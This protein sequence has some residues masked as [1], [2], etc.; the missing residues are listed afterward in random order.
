L[1][2]SAT[3]TRAATGLVA[4]LLTCG[5]AATYASGIVGTAFGPRPAGAAPVEHVDPRTA[6]SAEV[7][8]ELHRLDAAVNDT[9]AAAASADAAVVDAEADLDAATAR[10]E[11]DRQGAEA[12]ERA[13]AREVDPPTTDVFEMLGGGG[14]VGPDGSQ[15]DAVAA[16]DSATET[17]AV[18]EAQAAVDAAESDSEDAEQARAAAAVELDGFVDAVWSRTT[19]RLAEADQAA[20]VDPAYADRLRADE[21]AIAAPLARVVDRQDVRAVADAVAASGTGGAAATPAPAP[22]PAPA[23]TPPAPPPA[24]PPLPDPAGSASGVLNGVWC[25]DGSQIVVDASLG[26]SV[27]LLVNDAAAAGIGLCGSGFRTYEEQVQLRRQHC[28]TSDAAVFD[29]P[30]SSC[31]P[32]TARPGTSNHEDGLA[33]DFACADGQPMTHASPCYQWLAGNAENYG[34]YNLPSEPW[35][36]STTG[37]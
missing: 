37:T 24:P 8:D 18:E 33:I 16:A 35:H 7:L 30:P 12:L 9:R 6:T 11:R 27:Q 31:S 23:P 15:A 5:P 21:A 14:T 36:W 25:A 17:D 19:A 20:P 22:A 32:P 28:G 34:L 29:A 3:W 10:A 1:P 2:S 4:A 13:R 26:I